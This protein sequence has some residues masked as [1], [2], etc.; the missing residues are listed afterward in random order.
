MLYID[1]CYKRT[2]GLGARTG[3]AG[4]SA[5]LSYSTK[6][7]MVN[8]H[9]PPLSNSEGQALGGGCSGPRVLP[10]YSVLKSATVGKLGSARISWGPGTMCHSSCVSS[11]QQGLGIQQAPR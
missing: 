4:G 9:A 7:E 2:R 11:T 3:R 6:A 8:C 1:I 5:Q 10:S